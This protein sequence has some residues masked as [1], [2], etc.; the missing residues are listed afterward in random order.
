MTRQ[1]SWVRRQLPLL[2]PEPTGVDEGAVAADA[3]AGTVATRVD[4]GTP[5]AAEDTSAAAG[6]DAPT[7]P[8]APVGAPGA[9]PT[10]PPAA[11]GDDI[12][13]LD[14]GTGDGDGDDAAERK[15]R[16]QRRKEW[17]QEDRA[18]RYAARKSVRFPIFTR[19]VLLW[20]LIFALFGLA[21]GASGAF[22]WT[23]FNTQVS[24]IREETRDIEARSAEAL[25]QIEAERN[26]ALTQIDQSLAPLAGFLSEART[27]QLAELFGPSVWF[28][29]TLDEAGAPSVGSAFAVS[30]DPGG[31]LL[32]TSFA[33]VRAASVE[34]GPEIT[35]RNGVE[36]VPA[37][38][39]NFDMNRDLAL[40]RTTRG[41]LPVLD[42]ATDDQQS[43]ALGSRVFPVSGFG[44]TGA[45]LTSG[46]VIDQNAAGFLHTA[47]VGL[48]MQGG[49]IVTADGRVLGV[50][51]VAYRPLGFDP[52]EVH[53][54]VP[55]NVVC[56]QLLDCGGGLRPSDDD[57]PDEPVDP[58]EN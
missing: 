5:D 51:S 16:G 36:E 47:P 25:A 46:I 38:L 14:D 6:A 15:R 35:L 49:P 41:D 58:A 7:A 2:G 31:S 33:T 10:G 21:F 54:S 44:G 12:V 32:V 24:E 45:S 28:V 26:A 18:R 4:G 13:V 55:I 39:V 50:A 20:M 17:R 52:G 11:E 37:T 1:R 9:E 56:E 40:L 29:A 27:I 23:H 22:W 42:W 57:L 48:F 30:S 19:S 8:T 43:K 3:A 34:P 53:F